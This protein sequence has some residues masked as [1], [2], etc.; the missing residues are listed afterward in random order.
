MKKFLPLIIIIFAIVVSYLLITFQPKASKI[1]SS[2]LITKVEYLEVNAKPTQVRIESEGILKPRIESQ[3]ISPVNGQVIHI[4][5]NFYPGKFFKSGEVL[6]KLDARDYE[7]RLKNAETNLA[8]AELR[9]AQEAALAIQAAKDWEKLKL[10]KAND[11]VLRKPQLKQA[12]K[13]LESAKA[14]L[15]FAKRELA[16][17]VFKA[18]YSGYLLS[19]NIDLGT[20]ISAGLSGAGAV[21]SAFASGD[22]EIRLSLNED[23][24]RLIQTDTLSKN[25]VQFYDSGQLVATGHID[26]LEASLNPNNRL[27]YAVAVIKDALKGDNQIHASSV[28]RGQ[29]LNAYIEGLTFEKAYT[30]PSEAIRGSSNVYLINKSNQLVEKEVIIANSNSQTVIVTEG[31]KD[32]D[33]VVVGPVPFFIQGMSVN[34]SLQQ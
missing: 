1:E 31:L 19:R 11:L 2:P 30:L 27:F 13:Q 32:G 14:A 6:F 33:R 18:P 3:F 34:P 25:R 8:Q 12:E 9:Y 17:T 15:A 23:E 7:D 24:K 20:E 16:D 28:F 22:G 10:G 5:N 4:G 29:F 21:A 26:R